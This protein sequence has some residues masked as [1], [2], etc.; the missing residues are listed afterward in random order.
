M[1]T[2]QETL[3]MKRKI[4]DEIATHYGKL[5]REKKFANKEE[6]DAVFNFVKEEIIP[7]YEAARFSEKVFEF[8]KK[9]PA[10]QF[11]EKKLHALRDEIFQKIGQECLENLME[12]KAEQWSELLENLANVNEADMETWIS[13]LPP[14]NRAVFM[15]KFLNLNTHG[16]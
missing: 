4:L 14:K 8:S 10:F 13:K 16:A 11:L 2:D 15:D 6:A 5:V 9:F 1:I 7:A 3:A 12:E